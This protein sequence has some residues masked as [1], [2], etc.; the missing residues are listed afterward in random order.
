MSEDME[1]LKTYVICTETDR[2]YAER[3]ALLLGSA[4]VVLRFY[5]DDDIKDSKDSKAFIGRFTDEQMAGVQETVVLIGQDT[6][7]RRL[8][9]LEIYAA[10]SYKREDGTRNGIVGIILPTRLDYGKGHVL[11][12]TLPPRLYDNWNNG[13]G[14]VK[15]YSWKENAS[16]FRKVILKADSLRTS[17]EPDLSRPL[18]AKNRGK[19]SKTWEK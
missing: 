11:R 18:L 13:K 17:E 12:G 19:D 16:Y 6:W 15:I 10:L 3:L 14:S 7:K 9:D 8:I 5:T 2:S 4:N 1:G